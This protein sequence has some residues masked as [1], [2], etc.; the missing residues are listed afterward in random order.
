MLMK[1]E[2]VCRE[3]I[4]ERDGM[5]MAAGALECYSLKGKQLKKY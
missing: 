3:C 2:E 1:L 4:W 5:L